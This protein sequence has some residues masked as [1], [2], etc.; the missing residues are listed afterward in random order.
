MKEYEYIARG[1]DEYLIDQ[2]VGVICMESYEGTAYP[3]GFRRIYDEF[4]KLHSDFEMKQSEYSQFDNPQ[5]VYDELSND[6]KNKR[7]SFLDALFKYVRNNCKGLDVDGIFEA[8]KTKLDAEDNA[9]M[10]KRVMFYPYLFSKMREWEVNN[11]D[12]T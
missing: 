4:A 3:H 10:E 7:E 8:Y 6:W 12:E 9:T 5:T 11:C 1:I 2:L